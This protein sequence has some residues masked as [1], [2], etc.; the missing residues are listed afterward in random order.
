MH[1]CATNWQP[2]AVTPC[3]GGELA[4]C[5]LASRALA[6]PYEACAI[7]QLLVYGAGRVWVLDDRDNR[8]FN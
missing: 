7:Q 8:I 4:D 2:T 5:P 3:D 6:L 1:A